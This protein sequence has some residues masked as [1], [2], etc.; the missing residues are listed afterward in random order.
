MILSD[1]D[2][3]QA[4]KQGRIKITPAPDLKIQLGPCDLDL[5]LGALFQV[6]DHSKYPYIDVKKNVEGT[7]REIKVKEGEVFIMQPK[8]FAL[9]I[10]LESLELANDLM[11]RMEGRSSLGRI[12][13]IVH[14]TAGTIH[15]GWKG[16]ITLELGNF[17]TMPVALYPGMRICKFV[18]EELKS[19]T[20]QPYWKSKRA[21]Y[22]S[23]KSPHPSRLIN[24]I[25]VRSKPNKR[26][27]S[28]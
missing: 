14:G 28:I 15:P 5:H 21:K 26:G 22:S 25:N 13:I 24:D 8:E 1:V 20:S 27:H 7:M 23:Q 2:I 12:G 9:A 3:K 17:G 19:T 10:T 4:I 6:F 16:K 11:A 18:F